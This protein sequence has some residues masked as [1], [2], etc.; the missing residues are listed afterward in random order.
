[1][2]TLDNAVVGENNATLDLFGTLMTKA[3][4]YDP[5][6]HDKETLGVKVDVYRQVWGQAQRL[7]SNGKLLAFGTDIQCAVVAIHGRYDSHPYEGVKDPLSS[8]LEDFKFI[9]LD[10]CGHEPWFERRARERF[11]QILRDEIG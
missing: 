4:A 1:M 8:V 2:K 6:P 3:D 10:E 9:L 7:R 11:Y 5:L